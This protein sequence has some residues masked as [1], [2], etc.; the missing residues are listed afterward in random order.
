M[1]GVKPED[2]DS[3]DEKGLEVHEGHPVDVIVSVRLTAEESR[4]LSELA[5]RE[6]IDAI[7]TMRT[8]FNEYAARHTARAAR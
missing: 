2:F 6:G 8:A 1:E 5:E 4:L 3:I 7:E